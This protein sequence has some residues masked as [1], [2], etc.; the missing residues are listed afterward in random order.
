MSDRSINQWHPPRVRATECF[1]TMYSAAGMSHA[2][3][4]EVGKCAHKALLL[5][6]GVNVPVRKAEALAAVAVALQRRGCHRGCPKI[7]A[8]L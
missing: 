8:R 4:A 1:R 7:G 5:H 2:N 3:D 6:H